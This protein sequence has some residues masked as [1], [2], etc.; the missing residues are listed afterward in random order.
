MSSLSYL[1]SRVRVDQTKAKGGCESFC[2]L[3]GGGE[4]DVGTTHLTT[5][6]FQ[7]RHLARLYTNVPKES[8]LAHYDEKE[9][10]SSS[11][12]FSASWLQENMF[13]V[14]KLHWEDQAMKRKGWPILGVTRAR[15]QIPRI[16]RCLDGK[17]VI[18]SEI[19]QTLSKSIPSNFCLASNFLV[20]PLLQ[21]VA[22]Q[23]KSGFPSQNTLSCTCL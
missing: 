5:S 8:R 1:L 19:H 12:S 11:S 16:T 2:V 7:S 23:N 3:K 14:L 18:F 17:G 4:N 15:P 10:Q 20:T 9:H 13:R 21:T 6:N 22:M